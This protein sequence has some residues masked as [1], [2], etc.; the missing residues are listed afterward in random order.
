MTRGWSLTA[1][2]LLVLVGGS[3]AVRGGDAGGSGGAA[4]LGVPGL[5]FPA[6]E[7]RRGADAA[8]ARVER[9]LRNFLSSGRGADTL[10]LGEDEV[11]ALARDRLDGRLPRGV[12]ALRV[13]LGAGTAAVSATV[14]FAELETTGEAAR[15]LGQ[16]LGD[17]A[18]VEMEVEPSVSGPGRG[19]LVLRGIRAGGLSLPSSV[20]PYV[21]SRLGVETAAGEEPAVAVPIPRRVGA[22]RVR[23]GRLVLTRTR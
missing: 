11:G 17:S 1:G 6:E 8:A 14:R 21:L 22:V 3:F 2:L 15:R 23:E 5:L 12:R 4:G 9:R 20:F 18:R 19:R 7:L 10:V 13:D 16:F